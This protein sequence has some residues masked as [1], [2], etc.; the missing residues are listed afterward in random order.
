MSRENGSILGKNAPE[1][2]TLAKTIYQRKYRLTH[3][4][5]D[6]QYSR[7]SHLKTRFGIS[8]ELYNSI[9]GN[10]V[11]VCAICC[12]TNPDNRALAIDHNHETQEIRGLLCRACN[13]RVG[14]FES[15]GAFDE[16]ARTYLEIV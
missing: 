4:V 11:G 10:Q 14:Y 6:R 15:L 2:K 12:Q 16:S 8:Q 3:S 9:L 1:T 13:V 7:K 5:Q